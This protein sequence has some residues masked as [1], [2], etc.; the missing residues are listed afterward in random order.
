MDLWNR[1]RRRRPLWAVVVRVGASVGAAAKTSKVETVLAPIPVVAPTCVRF[2][3]MNSV[4]GGRFADNVVAISLDETG[5]SRIEAVNTLV[6]LVVGVWQ[7][8]LSVIMP[9]GM[10]F[11]G[12]AWTDLDSL[13]A[14]SGF[15]GPVAGKPIHGTAANALNSVNTAFLVHLQCSHNRSQRTGRMYL[16]GVSES[17]IGDDGI[18]VS[19][20]QTA[21]Q[22]A[23]NGF[24][25]DVNDLSATGLES[26]SWRV[27]HVEGHDPDSGRPNAWSSSD[28]SGCTCDNKV[29]TQRRRLR[30]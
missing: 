21:V 20:T 24:R 18:L 1:R 29:A 8:N 9:T 7:E 28:V 19:G 26:V 6:P 15:A 25:T 17:S 4:P 16:P 30:G 11:V 23:A 12:A 14:I 22:N 2:T 27:I 5:V 13:D 10:S 3:M